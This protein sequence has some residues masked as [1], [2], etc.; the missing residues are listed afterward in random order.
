MVKRVEQVD[1]ESDSDSAP[2]EVNITK[3]NQKFSKQKYMNM[4]VYHLL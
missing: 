2:E 1:V 4:N 3:T